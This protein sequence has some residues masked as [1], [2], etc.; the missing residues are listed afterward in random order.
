MTIDV[1]CL[2]TLRNRHKMISRCVGIVI[3][4]DGFKAWV[5]LSKSQRLSTVVLLVSNILE[6]TNENILL[7]QERDKIRS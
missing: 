2:V 1:G 6:L 7:I 4:T 3:R 5:L